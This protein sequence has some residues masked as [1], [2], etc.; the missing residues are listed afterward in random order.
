M[1]NIYIHIYIYRGL[2]GITIG[3]YYGDYIGD[4]YNRDFMGDYYKGFRV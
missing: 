2:Q 1:E 4:Y 3:D